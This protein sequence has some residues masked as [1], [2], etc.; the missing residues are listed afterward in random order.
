M[1]TLISLVM[2]GLASGCTAKDYCAMVPVGQPVPAEA[3][4]VTFDSWCR[5]HP[6][7]SYVGPM[8]LSADAGQIYSFGELVVQGVGVD[9]AQCCL[10]VSDGVVVAKWE[11]YD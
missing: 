1:R 6:R 7:R 3:Q 11:G 2:L 5:G 4:A 8:D 9:M 10:F